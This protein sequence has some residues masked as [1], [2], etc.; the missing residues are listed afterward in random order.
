M[1]TGLQFIIRATIFIY[2]IF[3]N[4][5]NAQY[6]IPIEKRGGLTFIKVRINDQPR[7]TL[8]FLF[9]TGAEAT[10]IDSATADR[11]G[12]HATS[13]DTLGGASAAES[14]TSIIEHQKINIHDS[15]ELSELKLYVVNMEPFDKAFGKRIDGII[16]YDL[17]SKFVVFLDR[18]DAKMSFY[19][20][21]KNITSPLGKKVP[22]TFKYETNIPHVKASFQLKN[23]KILD[24]YFDIDT[25]SNFDI[26]FNP[27]FAAHH[28][29]KEHLDSIM[30]QKSRNVAS[31]SKGEFTS[32]ISDLKI[33]PFNL[34]KQKVTISS[35]QLELDKKY[36]KYAGLIGNTVW[37]KFN[38]LFDYRNK[39]IYLSF[40]DKL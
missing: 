35:D 39:Y 15:V 9:D 32:E 40:L 19:S 34:G 25:G 13:S 21:I 28:H 2:V 4:A 24:G 1:N 27:S 17:L 18:K 31:A 3:P 10:A 20:S 29:L 5:G 6:S 12:L 14:I 30:A 23:K 11:L 16:G 7:D 22:I 26:Y 8:L 38:I 36:R 37:E 33:Q